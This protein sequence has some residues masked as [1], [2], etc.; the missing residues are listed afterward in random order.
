M[1][2]T[3]W[4]EAL[5]QSITADE[6]IQKFRYEIPVCKVCNS[7]LSIVASATSNRTTHFRHPDNSGCATVQANS[8]L[9]RHF[10]P[11]ELDKNNAK[12]LKEWVKENGY[13]LYRQLC[14]LLGASIS[15][16]EFSDILL[17]AHSRQIWY[18]VGLD[19]DLLPHT[20]IVNYGDFEKLN[21]TGRQH[22]MFMVFDSTIT[23][24]EELWNKP[25]RHTENIFRIKV[26]PT[27]QEY[28]VLKIEPITSP[29][30]LV[31]PDYFEKYLRKGKIL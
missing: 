28:E 31:I 29:T 20:L 9:Y 16:P 12:I 3:N 21:R 2:K 24:Y 7:K 25:G 14:S 5:G 26:L 23:S 22:K 10:C 11:K 8:D 4:N 27:N 13:L 6:W 19:V 15:M 30:N 17:A 18:Y 1:S